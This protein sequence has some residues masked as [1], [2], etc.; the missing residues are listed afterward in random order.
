MRPGTPSTDGISGTEFGC[1]AP[2]ADELQ[3]L[4]HTDS[5]PLHSPRV[6]RRSFI[7]L[8]ALS[9]LT[10]SSLGAAWPAF[11]Q[12]YPS[13]DDVRR[14]R[15]N[16]TAKANEINR[17][18]GLIVVLNAE[19]ARTTKAAEVASNAFFIAEE[20]YFAAVARFED[21]QSQADTG[22]AT[23][24]A[25]SDRAARMAAQLYRNGGDD[26]A[27][28]LFFSDSIDDADKI[29]LKLGVLDA[30]LERNRQIFADAVQ[31]RNVAQS[32]SDQ[33]V[34]ARDE[35]DRLKQAAEQKMEAS[36]A[37]A[38]AAQE[39]LAAQARNRIV[40]EAQLQALKDTTA[41]TIAS[42]QAGVE[43]RRKAEEEARRRADEEARRAAVAAASN[44]GGP[45]G[46]VG[47]SGWARPSGGRPTSRYGARETICVNGYCTGF[48]YGTDMATG[49][50]AAVFAAGSG[51]VVYAGTY[52]AFGQ[53][54][55]I[56]HGNGV[57]TAYSHI[58]EGGI[59]VSPGQQIPA[60]QLIAREGA[61]GLSRGCHL[62]FE[63]WLNGQRINPEPFMRE[64]GVSI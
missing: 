11:A 21:L 60:G 51:R 53:H 43:L 14:A 47:G 3:A 12:E 7:R 54:I 31:S 28:R 36:Q 64:R 23:A 32:L 63:V 22:A 33:A 15:S 56:D 46:Q 27:L 13:W 37:A 45:G 17:I 41:T 2:T 29:L 24:D 6:T 19:A 58:Q 62:H 42:Y 35:R 38:T 61:S 5:A 10:V 40:L 52:G 34:V 55:R 30:T 8:T 25:A 4:T 18:E 9:I 48:H 26:T 16:E 20:Q 57:L 1:C 59:L 44:G 50:G 39:A 49:C